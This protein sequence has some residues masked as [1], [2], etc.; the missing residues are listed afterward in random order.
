MLIRVLTVEGSGLGLAAGA[1]AV[2]TLIVLAARAHPRGRWRSPATADAARRV[3]VVATAEHAP[4]AAPDRRT[5]GG[6]LGRAPVGP[7]A[8]PQAGSLALGRGRRPRRGAAAA[9]PCCG[10][11]GRGGTAGQRL[12]RRLRRGQAL[13]DELRSYPADEVI[14]ISEPGD[15][16]ELGDAGERLG[17]P[18]ERVEA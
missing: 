16:D 3:L 11:A 12:G 8:K 7:A 14:L 5:G 6:R 15:A 2:A 17:L 1:I 18:L 13:E 4:E 10:R 9:R